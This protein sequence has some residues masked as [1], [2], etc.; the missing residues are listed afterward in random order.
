MLSLYWM[1]VLKKLHGRC[2]KISLF[3]LYILEAEFFLLVFKPNYQIL[4]VLI[5][6]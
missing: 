1:Y 4:D 6:P 2:I 3:N 5:I